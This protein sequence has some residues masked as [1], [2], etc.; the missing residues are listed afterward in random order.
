MDINQSDTPRPV[1]RRYE[2]PFSEAVRLEAPVVLQ[3]NS[4]EDPVTDPT[5]GW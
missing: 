5:Q 4:P 1:L 3:T 2:Q